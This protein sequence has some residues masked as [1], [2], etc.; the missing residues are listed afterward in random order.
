MLIQNNCCFVSH[1]ILF[2]SLYQAPQF[3][4]FSRQEYWS[5]LPFP[6]PGD[7]LDPEIKPTSPTLAGGFF[8]TEPPEK[9]PGILGSHNLEQGMTGVG[10]CFCSAGEHCPSFGKDRLSVFWGEP[11][12]FG[13][14]FT[15]LRQGWPHPPTT[16]GLQGGL[17]TQA[18]PEHWD[19]G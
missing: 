16:P 4:G 18:W 1:S 14:Q 15:W 5:G 8:T 12:F 10:V 6:S 19:Q 2:D 3:M 11:S 9:P 17:V 13:S 7:L